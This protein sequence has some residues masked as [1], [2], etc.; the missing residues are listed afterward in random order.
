[1]ILTS[2]AGDMNF[3]IP[4]DATIGGGF[5]YGIF[6]GFIVYP[7]GVLINY[8][9]VII[10]SSAIA[11]ILTTIVVRTI[12][13]PVT[14]KGQMASRGLQELQP[15][16]QEI[17]EKYRGRTDD[18]SKQR[19]AAEMQKIYSGSG[20][21]PM[22]G[23][24]YPFLSLPIFMGVWRAT[25]MSDVIKHAEPFVGFSMGISPKSAFGSGDYHYLILI[26]LV[27]VTQFIQ[28][29]LTNHLTKKRNQASKSYRHNP[30]ADKM[31]KQMGIMMYG[32]TVV[33]MVMSFSLISAMS[34]YLTVS[35]LIS[36]AQAFYIDRALRK[37]DE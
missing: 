2:C 9:S 20:S 1:M 21:N 32:F 25:S 10:G 29:R 18:A 35:A 24:L 22:T 3:T 17:E 31:N 8:L 19:K 14:L 11:M 27:G 37:V 28:F 30:Q 15:K 13:L 6:Q 34:I 16:I 12:T 33:M 23:M 5:K 7:V 4:A 36:I 26:L